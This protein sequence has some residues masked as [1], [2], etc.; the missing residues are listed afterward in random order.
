[1]QVVC[2]FLFVVF[3]YVSLAYGDVGRGKKKTRLHS[4]GHCMTKSIVW[5]AIYP[6]SYQQIV[7]L[8]FLI[9]EHQP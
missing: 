2:S 7:E 4:V 1:M 5:G 6:T 8:V 3:F 9:N